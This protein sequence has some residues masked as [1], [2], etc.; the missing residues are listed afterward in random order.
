[1]LLAGRRS[2]LLRLQRQRQRHRLL[3][4]HDPRLRPGPHPRDP[5]RRAAQRR[6]VG[7][8][9]LHRPRRLPRH[10]GRRP[11][12]ARRLRPV[13]HRRRR[14]HHQRASAGRRRRSRSRAALAPSA[15]AAARRATTRASST[16]TG[17][18]RPATRRSRPTA[19]ATSRGSNSWNYYFSRLPATATARACASSLLRRPRGH[20]PRLRRRPEIDVLEGGLTGD[21][22]ARPPLQP[23]H[24]AGRGRPLL[25]A[26]LPA[27]AR[28]RARA[29]DAPRR[30][31]STS[32]RATATTSSSAS[33]RTLVEYNL[34]DVV[35]AGRDRR[36][37]D[38]D[39]VRRRN[40][41]EWDAGWVPTLVARRRR[42]DAYR[43]PASCASTRPTTSARCDGPQYYPPGDRCPTTGYY[44]Y[45]VEQAHA[46]RWRPA[47]TWNATPSG[48]RSPA[49]SRSPTTATRCPTT[50]SRTSRSP[51][52]TTSCCRASAPSLHV[53]TDA[54]AYVNVARGDAGACFRQHLRPAGL[55]RDAAVSLDPEDVWTSRPASSV[56]RRSWRARA[57]LFFMALR[58]RD[59]L[60]RR[61]RRQ[62]RS[63]STATAPARRHR[64]VELEA[65]WQPSDRLG[66]DA[67]LTLSRNTFTRLPGV[68][69]GRLRRS[70]TTATASRATPT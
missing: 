54:D 2:G 23:A 32:S 53:A 39:L 50:R 63:A 12:P 27:R 16:A 59:R 41:D 30:R 25:P 43:S 3:V 52:A 65:S 14:R 21:A 66:L 70:S 20:P 7:R 37:R 18:C 33:D 68:R 60:R 10:R 38:S 46:P 64:G 4:L 29:G 57:N 56:R 17:R 45:R 40:V 47:A 49:A 15:P 13:G 35:A 11:D 55:L 6:R 19:T 51:R 67:T 24:L 31:R 34:P 26:P 69:L 48:S 22:E 42:L 58:E 61:P 62:R 36:S 8:A 1:M 9:L 28:A 5:Q 44:D